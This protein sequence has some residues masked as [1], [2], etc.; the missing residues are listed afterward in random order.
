[1]PLEVLVQNHNEELRDERRALHQALT[2]F[3]GQ[4][5]LRDDIDARV[6]FDVYIGLLGVLYD[7]ATVEGFRL[8]EAEGKPAVMLVKNANGNPRDAL[9]AEF[10]EKAASANLNKF[11]YR[12]VDDLKGVVIRVIQR[13]T[14]DK[15]PGWRVQPLP[16]RD[17]GFVGRVQELEDLAELLQSKKPIVIS[18]PNGIGKS[19]LAREI[20]HQS[21]ERFLGGIFWLN[22]FDRASQALQF[23]AQAHP[24]GREAE[25]VSASDVRQWLEEAPGEALVIADDVRDVAILKEIRAALPDKFSL[26]VTSVEPIT[27][28]TWSHFTLGRLSKTDGLA[29]LREHL[30]VPNTLNEEMLRPLYGIVDVAG[31]H[32]LG[33]RMSVLWLKRVGG[34]RAALLYL[35]RLRETSN[36]IRFA[37]E[38]RSPATEKAFSTLYRTLAADQKKLIRV[39]GVFAESGLFSL[40]ALLYIAQVDPV[41]AE[42]LFNDHFSGL[43]GRDVFTGH[44]R[45]Q[46]LLYHYARSLLSDSREATDYHLLHQHYYQDQAVQTMQE[47]RRGGQFLDLLQFQTA[48]EWAV[49]NDPEGA[50]AFVIAVGPWL[51]QQNRVDVL[52]DWLDVMMEVDVPEDWEGASNLRAMGDLS[53]RINH[54]EAAQS[55]YERALMYY[56]QTKSFS[57]QANT[58]KALG[59]LTARQGALEEAQTYYDRTL[60]L[61]AQID[62][63]LGRANTLKALGDL[64][65]QSDDIKNAQ[66]YY[67]RT[68]ELYEQI[69]FQLG[70]AHTLHAMGDLF[71][72]AG[73]FDQAENYYAAAQPLYHELGFAENEAQTWLD[74]GNMFRAKTDPASAL[75]AYQSALALYRQ[76][77]DRLGYGKTLKAIASFYRV[78]GNMSGAIWHYHQAIQAYA[79]VPAEEASL[80]QILSDLHLQQSELAEA[81]GLKLRAL[82]IY[83]QLNIPRHIDETRSDLRR[84]AESWTDEFGEA[85]NTATDGAEHPSW[86]QPKPK[87]VI[88]PELIYAVRDFMIADTWDDAQRLVEK[89]QSSLLTD[90]ADEVFAKM[91]RQYAGQEG[92]TRQIDK[93]RALLQRCRQIGIEKAFHEIKAPP[94]TTR[95]ADRALRLQQSLDAYQEALERLQDMPLVF[96]SIQLNRAG[97]L[98]ELA[99][100]PEQD[101][102]MYLRQALTAYESALVQQQDVAPLDYAGTQ[103]Q[104]AEVL[105]ELAAIEEVSTDESS[106]LLEAALHAY[107]E[108]MKYQLG[109]PQ[110]YARTQIERAEALHELAELP[111]QDTTAR[112]Q[113]ALQAYDEAMQQQQSQP[114]EY[115]RTQSRRA[116]L[117]YEMAG[118]PGEDFNTR[119]WEAL[120]AYDEALEYLRDDP[121]AYARTQSNRVALLRDMAGLPGEDRTARL[122]QALAASNEALRYLRDAPDDY[123]QTQINRAHLLREI[124]GLQGEHRLARMREALATYNEALD[125]L[126]YRPIDFALAQTSKAALL[127]ELALLSGE[128]RLTR[129]RQALD[130]VTTSLAIFE[131]YERGRQHISTAQRIIINIRREVSASDNVSVFDQWWE[132]IVAEPQ[133]DWLSNS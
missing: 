77:E 94:A 46:G 5:A 97:T 79:D 17:R 130:S 10:L 20:A 2:A 84:L 89:N 117:L 101:R 28:L 69:D 15:S 111:G 45:Q 124:A 116:R 122:Y 48:F 104:R 62:F 54:E 53:V 26:I 108:A 85:W 42:R 100:L 118:M 8:A 78:N 63:Q 6:A 102:L 106:Q 107:H 55:Y 51:I 114:H 98:R 9:L 103:L 128:N 16:L 36:I 49:A 64:S 109:I 7:D 40:D 39:T 129:L 112:M 131:R 125:L 115:A 120:T 81:I 58:L 12:D 133:P 13:L 27:E 76:I 1:M 80:S 66:D 99:E 29:L 57:G 121:V 90:Q 50:S 44:Y 82:E 110:E 119:M 65:L 87:P 25:R 4:A 113:D 126:R 37:P 56:Y 18:G 68:L 59:D 38:P 31:G 11:Y 30:D 132:Q 14:E 123:A 93:Y 43:F 70:Q 74:L 33:L 72:K 91:L 83:E 95:E 96:A 67:Q 73:E 21:R 88:E 127:R 32:P 61:Y 75:D 19:A 24:E 23:L 71:T 22:R 52:H 105:R 92:P 86:L 3:D 35:K 47:A 34:W 41:A 60:L